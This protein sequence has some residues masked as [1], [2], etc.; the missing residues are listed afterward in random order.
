MLVDQEVM[1]FAKNVSS[2]RRKNRKRHFAA[3]SS[4]KRIDMAVHL[5]KELASKYK[6]YIVFF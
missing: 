5:S 2:S 1:K 3:K 4:Q 6:V